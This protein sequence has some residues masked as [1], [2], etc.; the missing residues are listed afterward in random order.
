MNLDSTYSGNSTNLEKGSYGKMY[1]KYVLFHKESCI[2]DHKV[3][4][5][6]W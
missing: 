2:S 5:V 6:Q 1:T 4:V 3:I